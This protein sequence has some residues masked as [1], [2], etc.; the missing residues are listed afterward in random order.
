MSNFR[1]IPPATP[2][3]V[4]VGTVVLRKKEG[5]KNSREPSALMAEALRQAAAD[6]GSE[7]LLRQADSIRVPRGF[8]GYSDPGRLVAGEIKAAHARSTLAEIGILQQ[9]LFTRACESLAD[10]T[11]KIAL[12]VGGEARFRTLQAAKAGEEAPETAQDGREPDEVLRPHEDFGPSLEGERGLVMPVHSYAVIENAL[13]YDSGQSL[14]AHRDEVAALWAGM[15]RVAA[16]NPDAWSREPM[17]AEQIRDAGEGNAMLAFPYTK[18][19]VSQWNVDQA[20]GLI[21]CRAEI[22]RNFGIPEEKWVFPLAA[23]ESNHMVPLSQRQVLHACPGARLAAAAALAAAEI[24]QGA[25]DFLD[26]YSCFPSAVRI[27]ARELDRSLD[28][29]HPPTVT[30]GM[31]FAGGP[32]NNYV[33][34]AT[35]RM[36]QCLRANSGSTGLVSSVSGLLHKQGFGVW[37]SRPPHSLFRAEDVSA[38]TAKEMKACPL[39][40]E[41]VGK[42]TVAGYTVQFEKG[43]AKA[44]IAVCDLPDGARTIARS[45][46]KAVMERMMQEEFCGRQ[47]RL[48]AGGVFQPAG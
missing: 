23:A 34:Q 16:D 32:L 22:A 24:D 45:E 6:A 44:G 40:G 31:R 19:H 37:A 27:Q 1:D 18:L 21:L 12:I 43:E 28:A 15:S 29:E 42:A 8:W 48:E 35:A 13:R 4:G 36:A 14:E 17:R 3:L 7:E 41:A 30:G 39:R 20:A 9:T 46:E 10:G 5:A 11:E 38:A 47:V 26:L 2:V 33:L 25:L